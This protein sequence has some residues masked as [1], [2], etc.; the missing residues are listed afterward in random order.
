MDLIQVLPP[1]CYLT[2]A[3]FIEVDDGVSSLTH[4]ATIKHNGQNKHFH[5]KLFS[6]NKQLSNEITAYITAKLAHEPT[7]QDACI[8]KLMPADV[9]NAFPQVDISEPVFAWA[10]STLKARSP[11]SYFKQGSVAGKLALEALRKIN[12]IGSLIAFDNLIA[13]QDRNQGNILLSGNLSEF[14]IIDHD[15]APFRGEWLAENL[16]PELDTYCKLSDMLW[17]KVLPH[18]IKSE[19]VEAAS[20]HNAITQDVIQLS[21]EWWN[22]FFNPD[23]VK[24]LSDFYQKRGESSQ[25]RLTKKMK[26]LC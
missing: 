12:G 17:S 21:T 2:P 15:Q 9:R 6:S 19:V 7:P 13:N 24:A 11:N 22:C 3:A 23:D 10:V 18:V 16:D 4:V 20:K 26:L 5:V 14:W 8:I 25:Q 1:E